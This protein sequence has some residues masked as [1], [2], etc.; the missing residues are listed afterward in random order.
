MLLTDDVEKIP[1]S[2]YCSTSI[3][4]EAGQPACTPG[5]FDAEP[6]NRP[7]PQAP[8]QPHACCD[9]YFC[10]SQLTCM[11]PCPRGAYCPR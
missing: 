1:D 10:P 2:T 8:Q 7:T 11:V 4:G 6:R 9:G 5:F 3:S